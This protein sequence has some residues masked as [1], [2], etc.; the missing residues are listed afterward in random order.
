VIV[1]LGIDLVE[2]SRIA[3]ELRRQ[4]WQAANGVFTA[5]EVG[6]CS[7]GRQPERRYAACFAAKEATLKALGTEVSDLGIFREVEVRFACGVERTIVLRNRLKAIAKEL[8][9]RHINLSIAAARKVVGALVI[10]ES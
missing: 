3:R 1:G 8:G 6:Y 9:A 10:L 7:A 4:P 5:A 2:T